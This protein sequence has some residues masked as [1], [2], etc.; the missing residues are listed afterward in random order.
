MV[1]NLM[2]ETKLPKDAAAKAQDQNPDHALWR[3]DAAQAGITLATPELLQAFSTP[4]QTRTPERTYEDR[5]AELWERLDGRNGLTMTKATFTAPDAASALARCAEGLNFTRS[6]LDAL[7]LDVLSRTVALDPV[8]PDGQARDPRVVKRTTQA[9][10]DRELRI[11]STLLRKTDTIYPAAGARTVNAALAAASRKLDPEQVSLVNAVASGR[12]VVFI[13][14]HAG[15]GK[16]TALKTAITALRTDGAVDRVYM[17][18]TAARTAKDSGEKVGADAFGSIESL[19]FRINNGALPAPDAKTLIVVDESYMVDTGHMDELLAVS[20]DARIVYAGDDHQAQPIGPAGWYH[21]AITQHGPVQ[22]LTTVH[23]HVDEADAAAFRMIREGRTF[24]A[25]QDL[26]RRDRVHVSIEAQDTFDRIADDYQEHRANGLNAT[27]VRVVTDRSNRY[28]DAL[29][30]NLQNARLQDGSLSPNGVSVEATQ[31]GRE[32]TIYADDPVIFL[33]PYRA[34]DDNIANGTTGRAVAVDR[35]D[36]SVTVV[37]D[38]TGARVTIP[39]Q[40]RAATQPIGPAYALHTQKFQGAEERVILYVPA[41]PEQVD[42]FRAY[43]SLTRATHQAHIYLDEETHGERAMG[44]VADALAGGAFP[45]SAQSVAREAS[46]ALADADAARRLPTDDVQ[47]RREV[48]KAAVTRSREQ[49]RMARLR[50]VVGAD[51]AHAVHASP[52]LPELMKRLDVL[53]RNGANANAML[54]AAA[55][56]RGFDG[57]RDPAKVL[58][59]RLNAEPR[60]ERDLTPKTVQR[61]PDGLTMAVTEPQPRKNQATE[62]LEEMQ[63]QREQQQT[64]KI[65]H[66]MSF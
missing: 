23:R 15:A 50:A 5:R 59:A 45:Q 9:Q 66:G 18:S 30:R 37:L 3:D 44:N 42:K 46:R 1:N 12:G 25:L 29:N 52:A 7:E 40:A 61:E 53:D 65:D 55:H 51:T 31:T 17:A 28:V 64:P 26:D 13:E 20:G 39:M 19:A 43:S 33:T 34:G 48:T 62:L 57:A 2:H 49:A 58:I 60:I 11:S 14:G 10:M 32:W 47:E 35:A 21:D 56:K 63:Q 41:A 8:E 16:T 38:G 36:R 24:A 6:E 27:E 22:T 4:K 54:R